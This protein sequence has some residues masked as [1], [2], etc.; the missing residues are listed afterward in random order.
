MCDERRPLEEV[1]PELRLAEEK[2]AAKQMAGGGHYKPGTRKCRQEVTL[3]GRSSSRP[4]WLERG[5]GRSQISI[6]CPKQQ[7]PQEAKEHQVGR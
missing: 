5:R 4:A 1:A 2:E 6:T 7:N 3:A